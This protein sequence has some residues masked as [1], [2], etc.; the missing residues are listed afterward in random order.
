MREYG[1]VFVQIWESEDFRS[2]SE[3]GRTLVLYLLTCKH[4]TIAGAF[5]LPDGYACEDLQ[6]SSER[7]REGFANVSAKGFATRC[8]ASKWVWV[9]KFLEWNPP[10][11][12]N[13]R[14]AAAKVAA[15][16]PSQCAWK[17]AFMRVCGE[18]LGL[19]VPPNLPPE[20]P[21]TGTLSKPFLN[22]KQEQEQNQDQE[23]EQQQEILPPADPLKSPATRSARAPRTPAEKSDQPVGATT[24]NAYSTAYVDRYGSPP[25][26][27]AKV[28]AQVA[29]LVQRL[30]AEE[31]PRVAAFY[32]LHNG[33]AY[34]R[35]THTVDLLLR[36]AEGL[37]TQWVQ[38][39]Q[40][41]HTAAAQVDRTQ[42]NAS[43]FAPL[44]AEARAR[45][46]Q[47]VE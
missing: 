31:A 35:A 38:G 40:T 2:L 11:N 42:T 5:R 45:E 12:P 21:Q 13:Q 39:R 28:N 8:E 14:K 36:D 25:V 29:Q 6:W 10:E 22:Q 1:K 3:D 27:N 20:P 46:A 15:G 43:A 33:Q 26:R 37:R 30:G 9:T 17:Q 19:E 23:Q 34:V 24:W 16:I 41:T 4:T 18:S 32:V 7:V 47:G 44:I